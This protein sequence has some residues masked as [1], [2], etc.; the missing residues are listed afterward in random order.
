M[1]LLHRP[2]TDWKWMRCFVAVCVA[3]TQQYLQGVQLHV[4]S[5]MMAC[6]CTLLR[7]CQMSSTASTQ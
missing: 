1:Q 2:L 4:E 3:L 6:K 5:K 7:A